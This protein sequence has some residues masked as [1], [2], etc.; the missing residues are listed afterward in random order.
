MDSRDQARRGFRIMAR[1]ADGRVRLL[2][3]KGTNF[4]NRFPQIVAAVTL[5][6]ARSC[7]ID[8]LPMS[9]WERRFQ[10]MSA[11]LWRCRGLKCQT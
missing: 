8:N 4:S 10:L 9:G 1:R 6:P 3:R 7:L 5:L 11:A 2:T